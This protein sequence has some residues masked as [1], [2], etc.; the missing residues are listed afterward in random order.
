MR[1]QAARHGIHSLHLRINGHHV[2]A[3]DKY[4]IIEMGYAILLGVDE[5]SY[6]WLDRISKT[7]P[8]DEGGG[9][10][11]LR[12]GDGMAVTSDPVIVALSYTD[13]WARNTEGFK[14]GRSLRI[15]TQEEAALIVRNRKILNDF[16][17]RYAGMLPSEW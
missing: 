8:A 7:V 5:S 2:V 6:R 15:P 16:N 3:G 9:R 11:S 4:T 13:W 14:A 10:G 1:V 17:R 12:G